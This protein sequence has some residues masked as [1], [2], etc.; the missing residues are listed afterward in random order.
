MT[1]F[2]A[3]TPVIVLCTDLNIEI[4]DL[5]GRLIKNCKS[6]SNQ[7]FWIG[8]LKT[9]TYFINIRNRSTSFIKL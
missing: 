7:S 9:G 4:R 6:D 8:D 2:G 1:T 5:K 3:P